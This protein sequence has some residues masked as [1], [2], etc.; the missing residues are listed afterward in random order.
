VSIPHGEKT[1]LALRADV[2]AHADEVLIHARQYYQTEK[3]FRSLIENSC[4]VILLMDPQWK[5]LYASPSTARVLGY[6]PVAMTGRDCLDLIHPDDRERATQT[7][8][9]ARLTPRQ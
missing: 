5:I 6:A 2:P 4:D 7:V 3:R 9:D 1:I 8:T